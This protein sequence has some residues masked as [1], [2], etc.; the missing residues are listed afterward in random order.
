[1]KKFVL[2]I[3]LLLMVPFAFTQ[4]LDF[5]LDEYGCYLKNSDENVK[6][7][8]VF[9][10]KDN[11]LGSDYIDDQGIKHAVVKDMYDLCR[12]ATSP[13]KCYECMTLLSY[14]INKNS[15][16]NINQKDYYSIMKIVLPLII[17]LLLIFL[18]YN[19][20]SKY[21]KKSNKNK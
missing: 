6:Y 20:I 5:K 19:L 11:P 13:T 4:K 12:Y 1:M 18:S 16:K 14:G 3:V 21:N 15:T 7:S 17:V 8:F 10:N 2:L 9:I